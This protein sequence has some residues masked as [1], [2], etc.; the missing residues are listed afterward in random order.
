MVVRLLALCTG[1]P[2]LPRKIP[3][4][5][6]CQRLS[7]PQGHSEAGR[8]RSIEK[9]NDLIRNRTCDLPACS[10][11]PQPITLPCSPIILT[12]LGENY[13][14]GSFSLCNF[15]HPPVTSTLGPNILIAHPLFHFCNVT[16][17]TTTTTTT[18]HNNNSTELRPSWEAASC[19]A[20]QEL[21][22]MLWNPKV[23]YRV[24]NSPPLVPSWARFIQSKSPHPI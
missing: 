3:G 1:R 19:S 4:T 23:H 22:N 24:H 6:F 17:T 7:R 2:L 16:T 21:P 10:T 12:I 5:H 11:V 14:F 20:T 18:T 13:K 9:T 8:I 15:L